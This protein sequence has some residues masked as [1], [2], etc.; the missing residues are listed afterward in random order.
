MNYCEVIA[1]QQVS[2]PLGFSSK[3][4]LHAEISHSEPICTGIAIWHHR[5]VAKC[6]LRLRL[7]TKYQFEL[8]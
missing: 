5:R 2:L 4:T 7:N 8:F 3:H 1:A 6:N